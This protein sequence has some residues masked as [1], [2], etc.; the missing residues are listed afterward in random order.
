MGLTAWSAFEAILRLILGDF[1][2]VFFWSVYFSSSDFFLHGAADAA[3]SAADFDSWTSEMK[4]KS[5]AG[6]IMRTEREAE[7]DLGSCCFHKNG[8]WD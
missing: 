5:V 3:E 7:N 1:L 8:G 6:K 4:F 2:V